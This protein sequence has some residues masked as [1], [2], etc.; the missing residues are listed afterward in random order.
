MPK[1]WFVHDIFQ[2]VFSY[3]GLYCNITSKWQ[4]LA[5]CIFIRVFFFVFLLILV[6]LSFI[7]SSLSLKSLHSCYRPRVVHIADV[8]ECG[9]LCSAARAPKS[10][11]RENSLSPSSRRPHFHLAPL[12][13]Q[14]ESTICIR[15]HRKDKENEQNT[16][17]I[18][19][20]Q[21]YVGSAIAHTSHS[22][23]WN[24]ASTRVVDLSS[25]SMT[26]FTPNNLI[27]GLIIF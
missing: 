14:K 5:S 9:S 15:D 11:P 1:R 17:I 12:H 7:D 2:V 16:S 19:S 3:G 4:F 22:N 27:I 24:A 18:V 21:N 20:N 6:L 13:I 23:T 10:W 26:V 25:S 8:E